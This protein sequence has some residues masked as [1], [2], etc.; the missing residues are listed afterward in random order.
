MYDMLYATTGIYNYDTIWPGAGSAYTP[1]QR[2]QIGKYAEEYM[3]GISHYLSVEVKP[4]MLAQPCNF[5]YVMQQ[6]W[7]F[8]IWRSYARPAIHQI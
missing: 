2:A 4:V 3:L 8:K 1:K 6:I 5:F 7:R